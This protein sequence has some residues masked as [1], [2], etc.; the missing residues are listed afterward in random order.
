MILAISATY[1]PSFIKCPFFV[2]GYPCK[3]LI[4]LIIDILVL[5]GRYVIR[6]WVGGA[7]QPAPFLRTR[8]RR[9]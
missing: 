8:P 3:S 6:H 5:I 2:H 4:L 9:R 7:G 1:K